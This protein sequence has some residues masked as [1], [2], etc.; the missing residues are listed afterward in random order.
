MIISLRAYRVPTTGA[1]TL[2]SLRFERSE[3]FFGKLHTVALQYVASY[4]TGYGT[5]GPL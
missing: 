5:D 3:Q 4:G 2:A 1:E